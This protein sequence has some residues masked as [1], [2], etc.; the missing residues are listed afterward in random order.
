MR[1]VKN[2]GSAWRWFSIQADALA[3]AGASAWLLVP[4]DMR[5]AVPPEWLA[6]GAITLAALGIVGRLVKQ[7]DDDGAD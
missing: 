4:G 6:V 2:A 1:L 3:I 5:A 7:G